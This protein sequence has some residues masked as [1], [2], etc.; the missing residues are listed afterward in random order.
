[1]VTRRGSAVTFHPTLP[2][3]ASQYAF[4]PVAAR[5]GRSGEKGVAKRRAGLART[6]SF[7]G[8][9]ITIALGE[10]NAAARQWFFGTAAGRTCPDNDIPLV[11]DASAREGEQLNDSHSSPPAARSAFST[12]PT[13][14]RATRMTTGGVRKLN[15]RIIRPT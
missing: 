15:G 13:R 7:A 6:G 10:N 5:P 2:D 14:L 3:L 12:T 11:R 1:M 8:R 4:E 9:G